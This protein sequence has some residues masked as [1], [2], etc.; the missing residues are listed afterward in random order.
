MT[1]D[2]TEGQ[3]FAGFKL[4]Q[5]LNLD[6]QFD[7]WLAIN[8]QHNEQVWCK[9]LPVA[10]GASEQTIIRKTISPIRMSGSFCCEH[11]R[12]GG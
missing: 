4:L 7:N 2:F 10:L 12:F 3:E 8:T 6:D 11:R 5:S 1:F 9:R